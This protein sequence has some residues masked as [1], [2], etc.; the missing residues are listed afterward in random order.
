MNQ[1]VGTPACVVVAED[2]PEMRALVAQS[3]RRDSH[4]VF[5]VADG[6][7]LLVRIGRQYRSH[8][9]ERRIDLVVTD[10]R[11]PVVTG[12]AILRGLRAAHCATPVILMT[13]F[14]D[15]GVRREAAELGAVLLDK[16]FAMDQLRAAARSLLERARESLH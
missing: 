13:A 16:P 10:L 5:E 1:A 8:E 7:R 6:A 12:L 9:P 2:D 3:L 4:E 11:M 14:G 15:D